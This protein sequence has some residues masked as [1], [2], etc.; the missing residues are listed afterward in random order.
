MGISTEL[1]SYLIPPLYW[2]EH[3]DFVWC[4]M[5]LWWECIKNGLAK[6]NKINCL[7]LLFVFYVLV[8][9]TIPTLCD[10][11]DYS[12]PGS[13]VHGISQARILEW[14]AISISRGSSWPR[15]NLGSPALQEDS[16][17]SEPPI[18]CFY[19]ETIYILFHSLINLDKLLFY[20][21]FH[22]CL[23]CV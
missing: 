5:L 23:V 19:K 22:I 8:A 18:I 20:L 13:S 2:Y 4:R 14:V 15:I 1:I 17:P 11:T 12:P 3:P 21:V 6:W 16:L 9:K 7:L 10:P